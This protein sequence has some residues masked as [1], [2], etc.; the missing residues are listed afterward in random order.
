MAEIRRGRVLGGVMLAT[1]LAALESTVVAT[2]MPAVVTALGGLRI[3]SWVFSGFLLTSTVT[4]PLWG[5]LADLFGRRP[6]AV[7]GL[8]IFLLG[9]ALSGLAQDMVQLIVFRMIQGLGAGSLM[10][11]GMTIVGD[12]YGLEQRARRQGYLSSVW[13]VAS[14][15]G[16]LVGGAL[17]DHASWRWVFY[18]NIPFGLLAL[19]LIATGLTR[20]V[21]AARRPVIDVRGLGLFA[22]GTTALLLGVVE[23]GRSGTWTG[24]LVILLIALGLALVVAFVRV[25]ARVAEPIV[26]LRLFQNA[27]VRAAVVTGFL[28]GM[29]M[30]G[31]ISFVPLF[32][33]AVL[34]TSA[35]MAGSVL[36]PFVLGWVAMSVTSARLILRVGYRGLVLTGMLCLTGAFLLFTTWGETLVPGTAMGHVLLAGLGMGLVFVPTLIAAQSAV[37][38]ADLGTATAVTQFFRAVGGAI[39]L[40]VMGA[41]MA[42]R[43][44]AGA[45]MVDALHALF[46]VGAFICGAAVLAAFLVP[47]GR[48]QELAR[49]DMRSEPTGAGRRS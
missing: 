48:A 10:T 42:Q 47:A 5:R 20:E 13:G 46:V 49:H 41:V 12:L 22:A 43:L 1:F 2:A 19:V 17:A 26:P 30:F 23:A 31:A 14:L 21:P 40:S 4:M 11:I 44:H 34:G 7:T 8:L 35:M 45:A 36:T 37:P 38:R 32:M 18:L 9:S 29:A 15:L 6:T 16:P 24:P 28:S 3:Y 25:E 27:M 39:G 33:Q